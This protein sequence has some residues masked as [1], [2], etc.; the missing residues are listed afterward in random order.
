MWGR[1]ST[2]RPTHRLT[3]DMADPATAAGQEAL[4]RD[5]AGRRLAAAPRTR[6]QL[7][8][9]MRRR[10]VRDDVIDHVLDR[11]AAVG[12][13]DDAAFAQEWVQS[14]SVTRGL[15]RHALDNE[16]RRRG[17]D[18]ELARAATAPLDA[19][20]E[21]RNATELVTRRLHGTRRLPPPARQRRLTA[22]L[23]R[24]G[25]SAALSSQVVRAALAGEAVT[26]SDVSSD[27]GGELD[28]AF[29]EDPIPGD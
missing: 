17:V 11:F 21:R 20:V 12:L 27:F 4:A 24:R 25:Y 6:S 7:A 3:S 15:S 28:A 2:S 18:P 26:D 13:V 9:E 14:R 16:L 23:L 1:R 5:I 29:D 19:D 10:G 22:L 8:D